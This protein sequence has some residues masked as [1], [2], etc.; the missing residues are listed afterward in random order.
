MRCYGEK[1]LAGECLNGDCNVAGTGACSAAVNASSQWEGEASSCSF[2]ANPV[3][4]PCDAGA[5]LRQC[6]RDRC[7]SVC[8]FGI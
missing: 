2:V 7:G 3:H 5:V 4:T 8:N 1:N 6:L